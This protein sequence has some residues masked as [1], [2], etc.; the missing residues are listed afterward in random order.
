[1]IHRDE[2]NFSKQLLKN[3]IPLLQKHGSE[4]IPSQL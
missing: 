1:M 4:N 3:P 2:S